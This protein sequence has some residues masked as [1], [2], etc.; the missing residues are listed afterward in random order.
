[1]LYRKQFKAKY[2]LHSFLNKIKYF[3]IFL[4]TQHQINFILNQQ[5]IQQRFWSLI[6]LPGKL[7]S[8]VTFIDSTVLVSNSV[9]LLTITSETK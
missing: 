5:S 7:L 1:M 6:E 9:I 8:K 2:I 4:G 3:L